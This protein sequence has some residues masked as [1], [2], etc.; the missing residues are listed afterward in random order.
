MFKELEQW[1]RDPKLGELDALMWRTERHPE[2]SW[3]GLVVQMLDRP[4]DWDRLREAHAWFVD[5]VPRWRDRVVDPLVPV[6]T[7]T[8]VP[9]ESFDLDFHLRRVALGGPATE[10]Q[11]LDYCQSVALVP[12]DR[13]RPPW[14]TTLVEGLEGGRSALLLQVQHVL[15]DGMAFTHLLS[16]VLN[17]AREPMHKPAVGRTHAE[18]VG[19]VKVTRDEVS[20]Q[21]QAAPRLVAGLAGGVQRSLTHPRDSLRYADSLRRVLTPPAANSSKV[22]QGGSRRLWRFG[23]LECAVADLKSAGRAAG[24]SLND[25]FVAV[26]LGGLRRY[27]AAFGED[28][29]DVPISLPVAMRTPE[30]ATGG[31][32][33]AG[34][35]F[36]AP[37]G[38][39]DPAER[40]REMHRRVDIVRSEPALDFLGHLT[41]ALNR[42]PSPLATALLGSMNARSV[43]TTS[44]WP[45]IAEERYVAGAKTER[46]YVFAPLPGTVL[47]GAMA[48]HVGVCCVAMNA[49][50]ETFEDSELLWASMRESLAEVLALG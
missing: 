46:M 44:S 16:R 21:L 5:M 50:G 38:V 17:P 37:S 24:G 47:T 19:Q 22:L 9:D 45:G 33:F 7:P 34:A 25:T 28:L 39:A 32:K 31:N 27:C 20:R 36:A 18:P 3:T 41:P 23:T 14:V 43:L 15:M 8:W 13:S 35:F 12:L 40:I 1:G 10:R 4:P 30:N 26:L 29:G 48:T 6:G 49:D 42:T 2:S 11:F